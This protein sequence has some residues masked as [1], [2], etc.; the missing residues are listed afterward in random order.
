MCVANTL[1]FRQRAAVE[2]HLKDGCHLMCGNVCC[3]DLSV[4]AG[5]QRQEL[6]KMLREHLDE[7]DASRVAEICLPTASEPTCDD[8]SKTSRNISA[9]LRDLDRH[10][11]RLVHC[12]SCHDNLK[13]AGPPCPS[14]GRHTL[15]FDCGD[16]WY[17]AA[18]NQNVLRTCMLCKESHARPEWLE[19]Q[20]C[21][22]HWHLEKISQLKSV[23]L[24]IFGASCKRRGEKA[25][26][27]GHEDVVQQSNVAGW[28][29]RLSP[30]AKATSKR[31]FIETLKEL[32]EDT[33]KSAEVETSKLATPQADATRREVK[34]FSR[35]AGCQ[36]RLPAFRRRLSQT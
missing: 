21:D 36:E 33:M 25:Q 7:V 6:R 29:Q 24:S 22:E 8:D 34:A 5:G 26:Q 13:A 16:S 12:Y 20:V 28:Y 9:L 15:C 1:E 35:D 2:P 4:N 32:C 10:P 31:L 30:D 11:L 17:L 19:W 27:G 23:F 18:G 3:L 14:C